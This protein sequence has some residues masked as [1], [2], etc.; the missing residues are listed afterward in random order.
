[1]SK[2]SSKGYFIFAVT[3]QLILLA[4]VGL[5]SIGINIPGLREVV[6]TVYLFFVPGLVILLI[7]KF[8]LGTTE[9][10]LY[11]VGLS[12]VI[13]LL[14][15]GVM[16]YL[17][18]YL[19]ISQPITPIPLVITISVIVLA[20]CAYLFK[21]D[22]GS[23]QLSGIS[24]QEV[25]NP[26]VL[27]LLLL[28]VLSIIA[29]FL[30]GF[31][32]NNS[33][34]LIL[35]VMIAAVVVLAAV[36]KFIPGR[37]YP[38]L[39]VAIAISLL[40]HHTLISK[41]LIGYDIQV[42]YYLHTLVNANGF[43]NS[44]FPPSLYNSMLSVTILPTIYSSVS[45]MEGIW[46]FKIIFPFFA[47]LIPLAL[48]GVFRKQ[49]GEKVALLAAF[50]F[51]SKVFYS[52]LPALG[53]QEMAMLF[54]SL[55]F[56]LMVVTTE[57]TLFK[58]MVLFLGFTGGIV[59]SH[60]GIS[61][62]YMFTSLIV[63]AITYFSSRR[64]ELF[65][66]TSVVIFAVIAL[67]WYIYSA[68]STPFVAMVQLGNHLYQSIFT[69]FLSPAAHEAVGL[70]TAEPNSLLNVASRILHI[71]LQF[72]IV[73]GVFKMLL[74]HWEM[75]FH[76]VYSV[77]AIIS[78]VALIALFIVPGF[79]AL[80]GEWRLYLVLLFFLAPF[81]IIGG[82]NVI[83]L[84]GDAIHAG[85]YVTIGRER[86]RSLKS[87]LASLGSFIKIGY[88]ED[89]GFSTKHLRFPFTVL[90]LI[91]V[92]YFLFNTG[93]IFELAGQPVSPALNSQV[94]YPIFNGAEVAGCQWLVVHKE[95]STSAVYADSY[96]R[97]LLSAYQDDT[98]NMDLKIAA[99][100][101]SI[102]LPPDHEYIY[103]RDINIEQSQFVIWN[104]Q[105]PISQRTVSAKLQTDD[106]AKYKNKIYDNGN[107][108]VYR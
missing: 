15:G 34:Q 51:M 81:C 89:A 94:D 4:L 86:W 59:V 104:I 101:E 48:Y 107:A 57:N 7:M 108:Q 37:L 33:L 22:G 90:S 35:L 67:S 8:K 74:K 30:F 9:T 53:K 102:S 56:L 3:I 1:M 62:I 41:Y 2:L 13:L 88:P 73:V 21:R 72:F 5:G 68:G 98:F 6:G 20:I 14:I 75:R 23:S 49:T 10:L 27:V 50:F 46:V 39:I 78:L 64:D 26:P 52:S 66:L 92:I 18:P 29:A 43:W 93:F 76:K 80:F 103:L 83:M 16:N 100:G 36:G 12:Q 38:L 63:I 42:E 69:E 87:G 28:P 85:W 25:F 60:Y 54:L 105:A 44:A 47:A 97:C 31:Q 11:S 61:Y 70:I 95:T 58:R 24:W 17:Y 84:A 65:T 71:A 91:L 79:S 40:F 32:D 82:L 19:G 99:D 55:M 45:N 77:F 96:S 106:L